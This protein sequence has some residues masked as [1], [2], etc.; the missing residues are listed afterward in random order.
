MKA[1]RR[2]VFPPL[3]HVRAASE[4]HAAFALP[5]EVGLLATQLHA[6]PA[7]ALFDEA[8]Q[9]G[10]DAG[11]A[12]GFA[13][14][15]RAGADAARSDMR[16]ALDALIAPIDALAA[17]FQGVQQAYRRKVR[18]E[19]AALVRDVARQV[20]RAELD[21]RP[22]QILAFVDEALDT[23]AR[24]PESVSVRLNPADYT[25]IADAAPERTR[26]W[27]LVPDERLAPGECRVQAGDV[28]MD[29][30]CGQ[31]LAACIERIAAQLARVAAEGAQGASA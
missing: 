19:V 6:A 2:H 25:R 13:D 21:A 30:G 17:G 31:R 5:D 27:Q 9:A 20:V 8:R 23:L 18:G 3:A 10:Y 29:A 4:Q 7:E 22:E 28:E 16:A 26:G 24:V 12:D 11:H 14:G 15:E 1:Y